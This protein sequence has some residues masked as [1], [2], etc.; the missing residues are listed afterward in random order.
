MSRQGTS[1]SGLSTFITPTSIAALM[2]T[3]PIQRKRDRYPHDV[4]KTMTMLR[5]QRAKDSKSIGV[6]GTSMLGTNTMISGDNKGVAY[7]FE[8]SVKDDASAADG[9]VA[10]FSQANV[11]D[12]SPN[13]LGAYCEDGSGEKCDFEDSTCGD[14]RLVQLKRADT[15]GRTEKRSELMSQ[16]NLGEWWLMVGNSVSLLK[17][18]AMV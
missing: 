3:L 18:L 5:F 15:E 17:W 6:Q 10:G 11:G 14:M 4:D 1:Y 2:R 7:L 16:L 8:E 12:T 9:F 13:V